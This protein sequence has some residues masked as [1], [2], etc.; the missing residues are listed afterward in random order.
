MEPAWPKPVMII[1]THPAY[2]IIHVLCAS[3]IMMEMMI[4]FPCKLASPRQ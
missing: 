1:I 4:E 3:D 2:T